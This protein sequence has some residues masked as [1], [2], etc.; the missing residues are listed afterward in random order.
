MASKE[1][2]TNTSSQRLVIFGEGAWGKAL[3][4]VA[5]AAGSTVRFWK[6]DEDLEPFLG[7]GKAF[8]VALPSFCLRGFLSSFPQK[9]VGPFA[10][11]SKGIEAKT[12]KFMHE[13][14]QEIFPHHPVMLLGGPN[15]ALEIQNGLPAACTLAGP[16]KECAAELALFLKS[17]KFNL[18]FTHDVVSC[19]VASVFKNILAVGCGLLCSHN[20]GDN[21]QALFLTKGFHEMVFVGKHLGGQLAAFLDFCGIGDF[22]L[23]CYSPLSRNRSFGKAFGQGLDL[24]KAHEKFMAEGVWSMEGLM[25]RAL[26]EKIDL[27]LVGDLCRVLKGHTPLK[28]GIANLVS[29]PSPH[30]MY[31]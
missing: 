11:A 8:I 4:S 3:G 24:Q 9:P 2:H 14:A 28:Q 26:R 22:M 19:Q 30:L 27:P 31:L 5:R 25:T 1:N 23:T 15:M 21:A 20:Q 6:R 13:V 17:Q 18:T 7:W 29:A 16:S 12:G 10:I